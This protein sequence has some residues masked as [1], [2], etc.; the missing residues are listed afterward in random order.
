MKVSLL[1]YPN[2]QK[3]AQR[4]E[5]IPIYVRVR[6]NGKKAEGRLYHADI[7]QK[8]LLL[9]DP[10]TMRLTQ[11]QHKANKF[12][13]S[14]QK[15]FDDF[16]LLNS[17]NLKKFSAN[18]LRD[19]L[20][21]RN[22]ET[23]DSTVLEYI[24]K[25]FASTIEKNPNLSIG[26]KR[27][28]IKANRHLKHF[29][30]TKKKVQMLVKELNCSFA[31]EFKDYL[32]CSTDDSDRKGMTEPSALGNIK[33][34]RTIFDRAV[35]EGL[36]EK[37]PFKMVKLKN[38]SPK[39]PKLTI[40]QVK[41]LVDLNFT[42]YPRLE[43]YRDLF[44]FTCFTGL[45]Y[46]DAH[47]LAYTDLISVGKND[48]KV[49]ISREKTDILTEVVLVS[50]AKELVEKYK[51][52]KENLILRRVLPQRSNQKLNSNLKILSNMIEVPFELKSHIAR[53][54]FRQL[55]GEA[56]ISDMGVIKRMMG[57]NRSGDIDEV[58]YTVTEARL[59]EA[60]NKFELYLKEHLN[61]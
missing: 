38:R 22:E 7:L 12:I 61:S 52:E 19:L 51:N 23:K 2:E 35:D 49:Y 6:L 33:K 27:N 25:Y 39:K 32:L 18:V 40:N 44:L 34:F 9:W 57:Q 30:V 20:L 43:A 59:V 56:G 42:K 53:H 17:K 45:A 3:K 41:E 8:E 21:G 36:L 14:I 55:M 58:Y 16:V 29:L 13:T 48:V 15:E 24:D 37:N 60:K 46:E 10:R 26:T 50:K 4:S 47:N 54:T 31:I 11:Q 5:A 1:F 28:Y